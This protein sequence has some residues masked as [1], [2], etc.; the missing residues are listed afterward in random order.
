MSHAYLG[1]KSC[2]CAVAAVIDDPRWKD[3]AAKDVAAFIKDGLTVEHVT[4]EEMSKRIGRCVHVAI[5]E[6]L[7][8]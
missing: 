5:Q 4:C 2:G 8:T 6:E 3:L 1:V 7:P